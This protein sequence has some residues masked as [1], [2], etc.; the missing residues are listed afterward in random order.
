MKNIF[1]KL[2]KFMYLKS[3]WRQ[4]LCVFSAA[5]VALFY[6]YSENLHIILNHS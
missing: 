2:L 1:C 3:V 6:F 5:S 4:E